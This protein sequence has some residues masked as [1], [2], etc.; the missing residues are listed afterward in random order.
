MPTILVFQ[1]SLCYI[2]EDPHWL[3][4][5]IQL[6]F[7]QLQ[8]CPHLPNHLLCWLPK[9][10]S[11]S[12][13]A[14]GEN[15]LVRVCQSRVRIKEFHS[16]L[17]QGMS[18]NYHLLPKHTLFII[19]WLR[20]FDIS[21]CLPFYKGYLQWG[22]SRSGCVHLF[23]FVII[24]RV[25]G[26][27]MTLASMIGWQLRVAMMGRN[28]LDYIIIMAASMLQIT[29]SANPSVPSLPH[30][31]C[32]IIGSKRK[33]LV[34]RTWGVMM[35]FH[36]ATYPVSLSSDA[37]LVGCGM[38]H[39]SGWMNIFWHCTYHCW[40]HAQVAQY[41]TYSQTYSSHLTVYRV[42]LYGFLIIVISHIHVYMHYSDRRSVLDDPSLH[43]GGKDMPPNVLMPL[44]NVWIIDEAFQ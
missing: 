15:P 27:C 7:S 25:N 9:E 33:A 31:F 13:L 36:A 2:P 40:L 8:P 24:W 14:G 29:F 12:L 34:C 44:A 10:F 39:S 11:S 4:K 26:L 37:V 20:A 22:S 18:S 3:A 42:W 17:P 19:N 21:S 30:S 23:E 5:R 35:A 41:C 43:V 28:E 6:H 1:A 38:H 32:P 16:T